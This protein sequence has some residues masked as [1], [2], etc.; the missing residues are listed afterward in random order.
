MRLLPSSLCSQ[1][2]AQKSESRESLEWDCPA[3]KLRVRQAGSLE[4]HP[5][6]RRACV[7]CSRPLLPR[8]GGKPARKLAS[9]PAGLQGPWIK[10]EKYKARGKTVTVTPCTAEKMVE[11][12]AELCLPTT[13]QQSA[14]GPELA[15]CNSCR[16][17]IQR[18]QGNVVRNRAV[19][20]MLER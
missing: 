12:L 11:V 16:T 1:G 18:G 15:L 4:A 6:A 5:Y 7:L 14:T 8:V 2:L 3:C 20:A 13:T 17:P 19:L 10:S 9:V